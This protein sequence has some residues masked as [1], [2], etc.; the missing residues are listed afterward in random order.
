VVDLQAK[1][2]PVTTLDLT[3]DTPDTIAARIVF[4]IHRVLKE[5]SPAC[6]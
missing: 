6:V 5:Q 4:L 3:S 2:W 1:R